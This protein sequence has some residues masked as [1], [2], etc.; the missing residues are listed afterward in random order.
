MRV[1]AI[2]MMIGD[3]TM[4]EGPLEEEGIQI[5]VEGHWIEGIIMIEV[6][7]R[8]GRP[9]D[10]NEGPPYDGEPSDGGGPPDDGGSPRNGQNPRHPG[11]QGPQGPP[12]PPGPVRPIIVQQ[13]QVTLDMTAL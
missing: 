4:D 11:R 5:G 7:P 13:P 6:T 12:G 1:I 8:R 10:G 9:P 3:L 2:L